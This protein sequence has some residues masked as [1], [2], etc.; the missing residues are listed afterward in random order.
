MGRRFET[1]T[2]RC[3]GCGADGLLL[4]ANADTLYGLCPKCERLQEVELRRDACTQLCD[5]CAFRPDSPERADPWG[6]MRMQ[7]KHIENGVPFYCHKGLPLEF[8][9]QDKTTHVIDTDATKLEAKEKTCAG[10]S[11]HRLAH[12][13]REVSSNGG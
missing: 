9:A 3:G 1:K 4:T 11:A 5:N 10:W 2:P 8:D 6:W 13:H 7:E 12:C